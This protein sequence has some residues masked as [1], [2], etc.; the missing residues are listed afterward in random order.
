MLDSSGGDGC[1]ANRPDVE[2]ASRQRTCKCLAGD[3][4]PVC[5]GFAVSKDGESVR[6]TNGPE[7]M[8]LIVHDGSQTDSAVTWRS[9][10]HQIRLTVQFSLRH[11]MKRYL[12]RDERTHGPATG[13]EN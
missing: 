6:Q 10:T 4:I 12:T 2:L 7:V 11:V 3:V 1:H 13:K 9:E 8:D 5:A